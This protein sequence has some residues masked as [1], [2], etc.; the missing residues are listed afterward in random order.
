MIHSHFSKLR[1]IGN[2]NKVGLRS[3][4]LWSPSEEDCYI[5]VRELSYFHILLGVIL[6]KSHYIIQILATVSQL[7]NYI[8]HAILGFLKSGPSLYFQ[9]LSIIAFQ[10]FSVLNQL[11][12]WLFSIYI[13]TFPLLFLFLLKLLLFPNVTSS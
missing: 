3:F 1:E 8:Y 7:K 6:N 9:I 5:F 4:N 11:N 2:E 12:C 10:P 13:P